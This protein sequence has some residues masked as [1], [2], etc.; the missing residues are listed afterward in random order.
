METSTTANPEPNAEVKS[1]FQKNKVWIFIGAL[2]VVSNL[3][4][5]FYQSFRMSKLRSAF[6]QEMET[7]GNLASQFAQYNNE[8]FATALI[9]PLAWGIRGEMM[10]GNKELVDVFLQS[11]VQETDLDLIAVVDM[12]GMVYLSTDKKYENQPVMEVIPTMPKE[13]VKIGIQTSSPDKVVATA[14]IMGD[15]TQLGVLYFEATSEPSFRDQLQALKS[16]PFAD[17]KSEK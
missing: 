5:Y 11:V 12:T 15:V 9:K 14:P 8:R 17:P 2:F 10:R 7:K 6:N 13:V 1:W 4:I 3:G 16:N